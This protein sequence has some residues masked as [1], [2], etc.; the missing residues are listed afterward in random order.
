MFKNIAQILGQKKKQVE[1]RLKRKQYE[2]QAQPVFQ[3]GNLHYDLVEKVSA[4]GFGG[5]G[6]IHSLVRKL[7]LDRAINQSI[8]LLKTH[9]P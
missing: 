6:A 4:I 2:D 8:P 1:K 7:R 3:G 5:I 9:V